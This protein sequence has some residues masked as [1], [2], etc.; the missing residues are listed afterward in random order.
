MT[1]NN[2]IPLNSAGDGK[3]KLSDER[4]MEYIEGS[5]S[6]SEQHEIEKWLADEGMESD[7]IEGLMELK[8]DETRATVSKLNQKLRATLNR[9]KRER[10][11]LKTELTTLIAVALILFLI[12]I[13]YLMI[14]KVM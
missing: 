7:A 5:L 10:R 3:Q 4:L 9:K 13:A 2:N 11:G 1:E 6:P 12:V 14:R 8:A